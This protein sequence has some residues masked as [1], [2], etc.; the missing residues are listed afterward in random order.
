MRRRCHYGLLV[1]AVCVAAQACARDPVVQTPTMIRILT[2][3]SAASETGLSDSAPLVSDVRILEPTVRVASRLIA[4]ARRS[5]YGSRARAL[6]WVIAVRN[7][8]TLPRSFVRSDG[9][10]VVSTGTFRLAETESGLAAI[11]SHG[12][13]PDHSAQIFQPFFTTKQAGRGTGLGLA[14]VQE[15]VRAHDG[16]I[17]VDSE[18]GKGTTFTIQLPAAERVAAADKGIH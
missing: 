10:I 8:P 17:T 9:G 11:L 12:I 6:C 14:I 13:K 18:P 16:R 4:A 5:D 15:T 2:K 7:T 1:L 3:E